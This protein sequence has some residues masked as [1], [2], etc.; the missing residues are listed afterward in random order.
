[1]FLVAK[2]GR[3]VAIDI[4]RVEIREASEHPKMQSKPPT[5][6]NS[7]QNVNSVKAEKTWSTLTTFLK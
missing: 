6:K 5:T 4:W 2:Q 7:D 1:M 3:D